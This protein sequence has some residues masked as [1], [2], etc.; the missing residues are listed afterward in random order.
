MGFMKQITQITAPLA[1]QREA[2][3]QAAQDQFAVTLASTL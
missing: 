1:Q 2:D 3:V